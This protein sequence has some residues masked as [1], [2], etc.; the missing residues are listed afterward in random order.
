M[1]KLAL[2]FI[3]STLSLFAMDFQSFK[4]EV[5]KNSKTLQSN[6]LSENLAKKESALLLLPQNPSLDITAGRYNPKIGDNDNGF[7]AGFSQSIQTSGYH[8][9]LKEKAFATGARA[10]AKKLLFRA[11]FLQNIEQLY[12]EYV[13]AH[14]QY[15]QRKIA[16][17]IAQKISLMAYQQYKYGT[18]SKTHYLQAKNDELIAKTMI[19]SAKLESQKLL[20]KLRSLS[21][22]QKKITLQST[23]IYPLT[24]VHESTLN[25]P[26][27]VMIKAQEFTLSSALSINKH[28][29]KSFA[30][31]GEFEKEPEQDIARLGLSVSLPIFNDSSKNRELATLKIVQ[32]KL[33][34]E[35]ILFA[36]SLKAK[37]LL[38]SIN[39]FIEQYKEY[40]KLEKT[41]KNL[42]ALFK[43]GYKISKG[44]LLELL[45]AKKSWLTSQK[46]L[47][48]IAKEI[49]L[50]KIE[51]FYLQGKYND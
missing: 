32:A 39:G 46:R 7:S 51:L 34:N 18:K 17:K 2:L 43:E 27:K 15:E 10:K 3:F 26:S 24:P 14:K 5:I 20:S 16:Y 12:T 40:R 4:Q 49:N 47:I 23:Y 22:T 31:H 1:N 13:Y 50:Q 45:N 48:S 19:S 35:Q 8:D 42:V 11:T 28:S 37:T 41:Q 9:A 36:E 25:S 6:A 33:K 44:S 29:I 21:G 30:L 38:N